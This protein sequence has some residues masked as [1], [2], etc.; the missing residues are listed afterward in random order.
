MA[1]KEEHSTSPHSRLQSSAKGCS[2]S[3]TQMLFFPLIS[4][5]TAS[6]QVR[7]S[8][9]VLLTSQGTAELQGKY[10]RP[11]DRKSKTLISSQTNSIAQDK[12]KAHVTGGITAEGTLYGRALCSKKTRYSIY[13]SLRILL[14]KD[15]AGTITPRILNF[16]EEAGPSS[17]LRQ[18]QVMEPEEQLKAAEV[19]VSISRPRGL[20][21]P[22]PIQTQPQQPTQGTDSKDKG[23]GILVEEPKKKKLTLQQIRALETQMMR[24]LLEK[25]KCCMVM[26]KKKERVQASIKDSFKDFIPMDSEK[27]S[28]ML[29]ERD[30][31][32]LLRKRK[33]T[34]SEEQPSQKP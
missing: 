15:A 18:S 32:R 20:S 22:G 7:A 25:F 2:S 19:L 17:P 21:I 4:Q 29:K 14:I 26:Q 6:V 3:P 10:K 33:A 1:A 9:I 24:R 31:K 28:E 27:E 23:K 16:E 12:L 30:A 34:I 13:L 8:F 5:R 11:Q